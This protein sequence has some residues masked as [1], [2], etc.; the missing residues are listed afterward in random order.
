MGHS[1]KQHKTAEYLGCQF[2]SKLI[3]EAVASKVLKNKCQT[4]IPV[5]PK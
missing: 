1:I 4:K 3:G 2:D 5:S